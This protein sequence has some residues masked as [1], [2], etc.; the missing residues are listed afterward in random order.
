MTGVGEGLAGGG[1]RGMIGWNGL[2]RNP[3]GGDY[4]T[5]THAVWDT[6]GVSGVGG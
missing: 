2:S 5:L 3:C 1:E 6:A 4:L